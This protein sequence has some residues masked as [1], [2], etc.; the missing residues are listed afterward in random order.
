MTL[1]WKRRSFVLMLSA[2]ELHILFKQAKAD[3]ALFI[4]ASP[5]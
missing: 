5:C 2:V 4:L 1:D 3:L